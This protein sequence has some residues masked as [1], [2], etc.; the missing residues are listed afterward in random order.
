MKKLLSIIFCT[1]L[2]LVCGWSSTM[3]ATFAELAA[4]LPDD[5]KLRPA[6]AKA[7][8]TNGDNLAIIGVEF[9]K[10]SG[11]TVVYTALFTVEKERILLTYY[12][13][14][15]TPSEGNMLSMCRVARARFAKLASAELYAAAL[16]SPNLSEIEK[17][18]LQIH[19]G[20]LA[21]FWALDPS[22]FDAGQATAF[23]NKL[24]KLRLQKSDSDCFEKYMQLCKVWVDKAAFADQYARAVKLRDYYFAALQSAQILNQ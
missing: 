2:L 1:A 10:V 23:L 20:D 6:A 7:I 8:L 22:L 19:R 5:A 9:D 13:E 4:S 3:A 16:G 18:S 11:E 15:L 24:E 14:T 21:E 12:A 17:L